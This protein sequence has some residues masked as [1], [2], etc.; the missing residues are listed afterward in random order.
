MA[1]WCSQRQTVVSLIL[2]TRPEAMAWRAIS[3]TLRAPAHLMPAGQLTGQG[4]NLHHDFWGGKTGGGPVGGVRQAR[5]T[6]GEETLAHKL[7]TS[8]RVSKRRAISS[9]ASPCGGVEDHSGAPTSK[10]R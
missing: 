7:T 2:A 9:L 4:F 8:R 5:Q 1:S 6:F 3:G 10:I